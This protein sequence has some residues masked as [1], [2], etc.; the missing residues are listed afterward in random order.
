M[1]WEAS[2]LLAQFFKANHRQTE[3]RKE[4]V[5]SNFHFLPDKN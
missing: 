4:K 1:K 5:D 2:H 3:K